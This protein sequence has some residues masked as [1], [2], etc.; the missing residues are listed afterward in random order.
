MYLYMQGSNKSY[1]SNTEIQNLN[2]IYRRKFFLYEESLI[3]K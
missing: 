3:T 2:C 1:I